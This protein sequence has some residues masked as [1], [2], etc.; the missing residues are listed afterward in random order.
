[1]NGCLRRL[2]LH[3]T[4]VSTTP[5]RMVAWKIRYSTAMEL[6]IREGTDVSQESTCRA[7]RRQMGCA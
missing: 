4:R 3:R 2:Q 7:Q 5:H 1:M 6:T